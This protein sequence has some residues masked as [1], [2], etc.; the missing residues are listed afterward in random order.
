MPVA[1]LREKLRAGKAVIGTVMSLPEPFVA[2]AL[3]AANFDFLLVDMEHNP[4]SDYQLQTMLIA[5]RP[6]ESALIVRAEWND[7]VRVKRILDV[8]AEGVVFPWVNN[9]AECEAAVASTR[10]PPAGLRGCGPRRA[11]RFHGGTDSYIRW[12]QENILT[13]IQ[14]ERV[15][16]IDRLDEILSTPGLDGV[17]LGPADLAISMGYLHNMDNPQVDDAIQKVL[18]GCR[19][20]GVAFGM[21][22]GSAARARKWVERGCQI[23]TIGGDVPFLDAGIAAT[24][25]E[26]ASI[27]GG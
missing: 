15:D 19:R 23:A 3:G 13:L 22:T 24:K 5:A 7:P 8:G 21:F 11:A 12:A 25:Q 2:E 17:M 20:N 4:I 6:T 16:A 18:E 27:L 10:Y 14:I 9:R 26:I 1:A